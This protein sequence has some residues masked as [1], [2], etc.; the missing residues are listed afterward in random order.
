MSL[1]IEQREKQSHSNILW[2]VER[3]LGAFGI[4]LSL[5]C[6]FL[7][8]SILIELSESTLIVSSIETMPPFVLEFIAGLFLVVLLTVIMIKM[9]HVLIGL[10][11]RGKKGRNNRRKFFNSMI[12]I[13]IVHCIL[14][15]LRRR[16]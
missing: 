1:S 12:E 15:C 7:F 2:C 14:A 16:R 3:L 11:A 5:I 13:C 4:I 8:V 6:L 9:I 10:C